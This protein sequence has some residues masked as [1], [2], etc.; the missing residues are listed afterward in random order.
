MFVGK[1][2]D[3]IIQK[4]YKYLDL[5]QTIS[6]WDK[7]FI[8]KFDFILKTW[9]QLLITINLKGGESEMRLLIQ[10]RAKRKLQN[11]KH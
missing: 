8:I 7:I 3:L 5:C 2:Q 11:M 9:I 1:K 4:E 6:I 10:Y